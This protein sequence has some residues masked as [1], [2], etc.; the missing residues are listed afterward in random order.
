[1]PVNMTAKHFTVD[2]SF[3]TSDA[4]PACKLRAPR[5]AQKMNVPSDLSRQLLLVHSY[6]LV[7][8][9]LKLQ[10]HLSAAK[11]LCRV[12]ESIRSF[13]S[14]AANILTSAHGIA[15]MA[16]SVALSVFEEIFGKVKHHTENLT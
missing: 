16:F 12:S 4:D 14:H 5:Q 7:K 3:Q 15:S 8:H 2:V 13:P 9:F 11:M 1:M 6:T 10:D